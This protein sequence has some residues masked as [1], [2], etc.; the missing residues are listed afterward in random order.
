MTETI[1]PKIEV[2]D[3]FELYPLDRWDTTIV[4]RTNT[5]LEILISLNDDA[6]YS[7]EFGQSKRHPS[8]S[9]IV[10]A[11]PKWEGSKIQFDNF[12]AAVDFVN[13][14]VDAANA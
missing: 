1:D 4:R 8:M 12:Q 3:G 13:A 14:A 2:V 7:V 9:K 11:L 5:G 6:T 10:A